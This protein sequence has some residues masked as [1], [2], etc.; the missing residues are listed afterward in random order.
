MKSARIRLPEKLVPVFDGTAQYR[1][2]YGGRG[3]GKTRS[4]A[5]MSAIHGY[6]CAMAGK[7]GVIVCGR[8]F[9][10]SLTDSS[11]A[12]V[13]AAIAAEPWLAEHYAVGEQFIRTKNGAIEFVFLGLRR[14]VD[15]IKS[16]SRIR[17][18]WAD[19]AEPIPESSW[20]KIL[21]SIREE[22]S[23]TWVTWNPERK[24]SATNQRF[25]ENP[26][27]DSKIIELNWRDNPWFPSALDAIRRE[28]QA[29]RPEQYDHIWEGDY[30]TVHAGAY[31]AALLTQA[32]RDG[33]IGRVPRDPLMAL[34]AFWDIGGTGRWSDACAIWIGQFVGR[35]IRWLD[36]YEAQG[37]PLAAHVDWLR[38][39]GY[40]KAL[41]TLPHDG[42]TADRV[43]NVSYKSALQEAG[44]QVKVIPN[45]G[46]GAARMRIESARRLFSSMWFNKDTTEPGREAL[47][48]YHEKKSDDS[49]EIGLGP[50]HDWSSHCADAFGLACVA[51]EAPEG[52][53]AKLQTRAKISFDRVRRYA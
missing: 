39:K 26:P 1:G 9:Q 30:A 49:R 35:E 4:F 25:R 29:K 36:Y 27:A 31:Y 14:N 53:P 23:E 2:A 37:Q 12:E 41:C 22:G 20:I 18:F 5:M 44:F 6:R 7:G 47:G 16:L 45:Q 46:A 11:M 34:R 51:Y 32:E 24:A 38:S 42:E 52:A 28:D 19:E 3:S 48:W 10:N 21:P 40:D 15:S 43:H 13:K 50:D 17:L 33:R 8:E